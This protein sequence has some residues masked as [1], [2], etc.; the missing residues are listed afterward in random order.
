MAAVSAIS[1]SALLDIISTY[2]AAEDAV[3]IKLYSNNLVPSVNSVLGDFTEADFTGY[4]PILLTGWTDAAWASQGAAVC[5]GIPSAVFNAASPFTVGQT[6]FGW[7]AVAGSS[8]PFTLLAAGSFGSGI[9]M[10]S[11]GD[12]ILIS[13]PVGISDAGIPVVVL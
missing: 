1:K 3:H 5:Y 12:Q 8:S 6:V 13:V 11:L 9:P 4:A 10:A 2:L 7:Y